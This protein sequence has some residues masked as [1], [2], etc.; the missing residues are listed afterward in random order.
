MAHN[1]SSAAAVI[2]VRSARSV[3]ETLPI[4]PPMPTTSGEEE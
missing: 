4:V 2:A 3:E 1:P